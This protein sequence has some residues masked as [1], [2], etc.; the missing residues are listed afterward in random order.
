MEGTLDR[1]DSPELGRPIHTWRYGHYGPPVLVFPSASGMAHEWQKE[2][3]IE[4]L[5]PLLRAGR[6]KLYCV[7]SNV[8]EA[9][10]RKEN[11]IGWRMDRHARYERWVLDRMVPFIRQDC[12]WHDAPIVS[13]G[14]SL[15]GTYAVNFA[16][17]HPEVFRHGIGL[18]GRY[19]TTEVAGR[20]ASPDLYFN[21]PLA[22]M[23]N[24]SGDALERVRRNTRLTI[25]C[26][27]GKWEEGCIEETIALGALCDRIGVACDTDIWGTESY[28]DWPW[29]RR[30]LV[31]HFGRIFGR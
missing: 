13:V 21:N 31:H 14:A 26:G 3:M 29:W 20:H 9:W 22:Y 24:I 28:H 27:R 19:L 17:K 8:S 4:A 30:Q 7:E 10:T 2:G 25:V 6:L 12:R 16:L 18:S 23:S 11:P 15:G 1:V 5:A